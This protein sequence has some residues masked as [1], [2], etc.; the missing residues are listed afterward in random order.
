M[1]ATAIG[2]M[3]VAWI[4]GS[5]MASP[6]VQAVHGVYQTVYEPGLNEIVV[7]RTPVSRIA[8]NPATQHS[9]IIE[10]K[11]SSQPRA[12]REVYTLPAAAEWGMAEQKGV[13]TDRKSCVVRGTLAPGQKYMFN[14]WGMSPG[15]PTGDY[16]IEVYIE[17]TLVKTFHFEVVKKEI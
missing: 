12:I 1:K 11:P 10:V 14:T 13:S 4:G 9:W 15:D 16:K 2:L 8:L 3:V 17:D 5:A 6:V 7:R